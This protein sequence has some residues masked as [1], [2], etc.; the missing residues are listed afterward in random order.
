MPLNDTL[1][2]VGHKSNK[3][4]VSIETA[5]HRPKIPMRRKTRHPM[6]YISEYSCIPSGLISMN[7]CSSIED[8]HKLR[9]I[10]RALTTLFW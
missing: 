7:P 4:K 8:L 6:W 5:E 2:P 10:A 3:P 9:I 1:I